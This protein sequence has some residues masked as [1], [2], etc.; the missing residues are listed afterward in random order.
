M[1]STSLL[2]INPTVSNAPPS[3]STLRREIMKTVATRRKREP[4]RSHPN[5]R[6]F[7][8]FISNSGSASETLTNAQETERAIDMV[9]AIEQ[10]CYQISM[11]QSLSPAHFQFFALTPPSMLSKCNLGFRDLSLLASLEV[12]RYT[13]Q[14]LLQN[15]QNISHFLGGKNWTYF[16]YVPS[17]YNQNIVI[18]NATDCVLARI[19]SA[20]TP[21]DTKW[22]TLAL[23]AYLKALLCLQEAMNTSLGP[24]TAETL[25]ATQILGL[26][27]LLNPNRESAWIKHVA[28]AASIIELRGPGSY[29]SDFEKSLFMS[30]VGPIVTESILNNQSCFLDQP[31]WEAVF[32]SIIT[33][34]PLVPERSSKAI[35][36]VKILVSIPTL[37]KD[38]TDA[39]CRYPDLPLTTLVELMSRAQ[40]L[41]SSLQ[42]WSASYAG[43]NS[44]LDNGNYKIVVM[45][46][47][48][49]IYS[50]RLNTCIHYRMRIPD[51]I[52]MEEESQ[53]FANIIVSL[54][55][56]K[57]AY[58]SLQSSLLL[59][60][61]LPIA[62]ATI[63]TGDDWRE[64]LMSNSSDDQLFKIPRRMFTRWYSLF[65]RNTS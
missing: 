31:A 13:G 15:P 40:N 24:P 3:R 51:T 1:D 59:A 50:N 8:V 53:Q 38:L 2:W 56:Q 46:Y 20:L 48:C 19:K 45:F 17:Q 27:E 64:Q 33:D 29:G 52:E 5:G 55:S 54:N 42:K 30:H 18:R 41:Q 26:Y 43:L 47:L 37:F 9:K 6:Q 10:D 25:C 23:S 16:R 21:E 12:G 32:Q 57:E 11:D 14:R 49:T 60:Q 7:P 61:K 28:G 4:K 58:Y 34:D 44:T 35:S 63:E 36:L 22:E 62:E 65:G 39:I